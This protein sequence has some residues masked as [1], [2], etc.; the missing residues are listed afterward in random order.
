MGPDYAWRSTLQL[1]IRG[2]AI[3]VLAVPSGWQ[4][5]SSILSLEGSG[6]VLH[7]WAAVAEGDE[8]FESGN[9]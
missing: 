2:R 5:S 4:Y 9:C 1:A 6:S 3:L 7:Q 8:Y